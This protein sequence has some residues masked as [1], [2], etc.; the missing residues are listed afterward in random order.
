MAKDF[1]ALNEEYTEIAAELIATEPQLEYIKHSNVQIGYLNSP[2]RKHGTNKIVHAECSKVPDKYK[3]SIPF[4][5]LITVFD[6]NVADFTDAQI[7]ILLYHELLHVGI[8]KASDDEKYY[9]VPH[10]LE[11][12]KLI[13][14]KFGTRWSE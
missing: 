1:R 10:D 6:P 2:Y 12:F 9:V 4:D 14:D 5:F 7:R 8:D 11:D 13:V 3:W